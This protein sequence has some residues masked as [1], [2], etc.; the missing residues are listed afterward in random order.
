[1]L[2]TNNKETFML[3]TYLY[4]HWGTTKG[5]WHPLALS[6]DVVAYGRCLYT[7]V[8]GTPQKHNFLQSSNFPKPSLKL[9]GT[10]EN[11]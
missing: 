3:E 10:A 5:L 8:T 11:H 9:L 6:R 4:L 2:T 1:M 7:E